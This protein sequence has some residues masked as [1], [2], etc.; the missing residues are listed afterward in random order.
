MPLMVTTATAGLL[1]VTALIIAGILFVPYFSTT[2]RRIWEEYGLRRTHW[3]PPLMLLVAM[4]ADWISPGRFARVIVDKYGIIVFILTLALLAEGMREAGLFQF[5][6]YRIVRAARGNT[7]MMVMGLFVLCSAATYV[8]TN[9]VV[10]L[11]FTPLFLTISYR[12][13]LRYATPL[14]L[15]QF[16]AANTV[17]AGL[18]I[19]TPTNIIVS[20]EIG[21]SFVE[22]FWLMLKPTALLFGLSSV[23]ING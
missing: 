18:Y 19:G 10:V 7:A 3:L 16:V 4:V 17:S 21:L 22:Y 2:E 8:T 11:V 15:M 6:A 14:M 5:L 23:I 12:T 1:F 20:E 9:D 13:G